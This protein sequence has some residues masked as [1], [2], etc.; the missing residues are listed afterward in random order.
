MVS[1]S[2]N[3][4]HFYLNLPLEKYFDGTEKRMNSCNQRSTGPN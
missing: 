3:H 1:G 4:P 2:G